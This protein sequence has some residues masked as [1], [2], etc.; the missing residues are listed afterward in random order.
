LFGFGKLEPMPGSRTALCVAL[1]V[2]VLLSGCMDL[3]VGTGGGNTQTP[4]EPDPDAVPDPDLGNVSDDPNGGPD[5]DG[6]RSA[7]LSA[8]ADVGT[9]RVEGRL[10]QAYRAESNQTATVNTTTLVNRTDRTLYTNQTRS[11]GDRTWRVETYHVDG[12]TYS[13]STFYTQNYGSQWIVRRP[14]NRTRTWNRLDVLARQ[15][16]VL[17]AA[18][19]SLVN[20]TSVDGTET[21]L[22]TAELSGEAYERLGGG[23]L[24]GA[25]EGGSVTVESATIWFWIATDSH[26]P[27]RSKGSL[28]LAVTVE[29]TNTAASRTIRVEQLLTLDYR[30]YGGRVNVSLPE[31]ATE[32]AVNLST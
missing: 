24:A 14:A 20:T 10:V 26:L 13:Q 16:A 28:D 27:V 3:G 32:R 22:V 12:A 8:M 18:N 5:P 15:R 4:T 31:R 6:I 7:A 29:G 30:G 17:A 21:Y 2:A 23:S 25:A 1:A 19:V 11:T 9:Y